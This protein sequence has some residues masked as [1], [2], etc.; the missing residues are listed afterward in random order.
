M[1]PYAANAALKSK[2]KQTN[3]QKQGEGGN[4]NWKV[5]TNKSVFRSK[6]GKNAY[7]KSDYK[8]KEQQKHKHEDV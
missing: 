4:Q 7:C 3:K 1:T 6:K 5:I 8:R 2:N